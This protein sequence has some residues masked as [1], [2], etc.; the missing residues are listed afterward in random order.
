MFKLRAL[1][2]LPLA[3]LPAAIAI[4]QMPSDPLR[5]INDPGTITTRQTISPAGVQSIF[6]GRVQGV[7]FGATNSDIW[8][9]NAG[10]VFHMD[11]AAN[12]VLSKTQL[13][14]N[15]GLQGIRYDSASRTALV[16][17]I[18]SRTSRFSKIDAQGALTVIAPEL[19]RNVI[20]APDYSPKS[21]V[22]VVPLT[23]DNK[24][25]VLDI[26]TG[27]VIYK[28]DTGMVPFAAVVNTEGSIAYVSNWGGRR[29][30]AQDVTA[31]TGL[32]ADA[33]RV[34]VDSRGI[35]STGTLT[36]IDI[37]AGRA[38]GE[39]AVGLHPTAMLW[40]QP[41]A[42]L[43]V[44]NG[45]SDSIS[46]VDTAAGKVLKTIPLDPF[47]EKVAGIAPTALAL[48][49][50]GATLYVA[51]GGINA[52]ASVQTATGKITGLIPT[53]WYPSALAL[54]PDARH[55]AV[56][57]LF[58]PGSGSS[59][60]EKRRFVHAVRGSVA[61]IELPNAEHL[62]SYTSAVAAN[63]R[64]ALGKA[65]AE[66]VQARATAPIPVP[67]KAG[68]P[69]PIENVVFIIK[70]NR[71]YDQVLGDLAK[72]NNDA[73]LVMYGR[74]VTPNQHRLAEEF[75]LLDNFYATGGNSADGHQWLTQANETDYGMWPGYTNRSYSFD[76]S[77]PVMPASTG[78]LWDAALRQKK[79]VRV[80]G[81]Y[82][83]VE[84]RQEPLN[85][86]ALLQG[87][88][89][90]KD[91]T[92]HWNTIA[93]TAPLNKLLAA[94][95][96][97]YS[98]AIPDVIRASIFLAE[99]RK[100]TQAGQMPNLTL[101]ALPSNHTDGAVPGIST[102]KA[103]VADNDLA[104][105]QIVEGLSKSPFWKKMAIFIVEDDAQGGVDHVDGHRTTAFV[106][107]PYT[108]RGT[109][110]STFYSH[111]SILKTIELILG[112][113]TLTIFDRIANDMR[114]CFGAEVN[115]APYQAIAPKQSLFE[116]N[117][118]TSALHG[119]ARSD[120][121]AS[122]KM[123]WD[124][125]DAAPSDRLNRILWRLAKGESTPYPKLRQSVFSPY[126]IDID[127]DDRDRRK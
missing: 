11:W 71:S 9:L 37:L 94:N 29:P 125:P 6:S 86:A 41:H 31:K 77:D 45:N 5:S 105:G 84:L 53:A 32:A 122:S 81:E 39:I 74:D 44:A 28:V 70:E 55:L 72:G 34:V 27:S 111:Q 90:G 73:S 106:V 113:H 95:Y 97:A 99:L 98:T 87:W 126:S 21:H 22:A 80:F 65:V 4:A 42:R 110:D 26:A 3:V 96:P 93:P 58:G 104:V 8:V 91:F 120:A 43:Y 107:S 25:A 69:T 75:V 119:R 46:V 82:A 20:G 50:D 36:R 78:F 112:T 10:Q 7:A 101:I 54:S 59:G 49:P 85:R 13:G 83:G 88:K 89:D 15:S 40:D 121:I 33:D 114:A 118:A 127:D 67:N 48:S 124:V 100:W 19:G 51:C 24:V 109:I 17:S 57:T 60:G 64:M 103:M 14:G 115:A 102:P 62:F 23:G 35:A 92:H 116:I 123:R 63:N 117:P 18:E 56:T 16:S 66:P 52:I 30:G 38:D 2:M 47:R 61:V 68:D 79:T 76:G 1:A 108:R 12:K